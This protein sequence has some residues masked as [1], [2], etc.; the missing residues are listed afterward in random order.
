MHSDPHQTKWQ[1]HQP[2]KWIRDQRQQCQR[3]AQHEEQTPQKESEHRETLLTLREIRRKL[4][5]SST[6]P[7]PFSRRP[8]GYESRSIP[9]F[10]AIRRTKGSLG[11]V[12]L[13][14]ASAIRKSLASAR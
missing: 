1:E 11:C 7:E 3:P 4:S 8:A 9:S 14:C 2:D 13:S 12:L 5:Y 6:M 10:S